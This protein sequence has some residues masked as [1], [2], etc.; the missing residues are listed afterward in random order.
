[1][2]F[3]PFVFA[4]SG[5]VD[6]N[7]AGATGTA[8]I[9]SGI[10]PGAG[11]V[12]QDEYVPELRGINAYKEYDKMRKSDGQVKGILA[13]IKL[14]LLAADWSLQ[15]PPDP[16]DT[17]RTNTEEI[18][19]AL[20]KR[21]W[22]YTLRHILL[23]LDFGSMPMEKVWTIE[24]G[25]AV[26]R[27]SPRLPRTVVEWNADEHGDFMGITQQVQ[28]SVGFKQ[29]HIEA[30]KLLLFINELEGS[31]FRGLS[32]LRAARKDW[33][34]KDKLQRINAITLEKRGAGID[35]GTILDGDEAIKG[36]A[37]DVLMQIRTHER[38]YVLETP[39]F[40]YRQD[41]LGASGTLSPLESIKYHDWSMLFGVMAQFLGMG[42]GQG[43]SFAMHADKTSFFLMSLLG[44]SGTVLEPFNDD[45]LPQWTTYNY[46]ENVR[47][48]TLDHSRLDRRD[49]ANVVE[50]LKALVPTGVIGVT[51]E[52]EAWIRGLLEMPE[53]AD[54]SAMS[55]R[56]VQAR[57][58]TQMAS[59]LERRTFDP[60]G[61][62]TPFIGEMAAAMGSY[63][64]ARKH[65]DALEDT[66]KALAMVRDSQA[67][68]LGMMSVGSKVHG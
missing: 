46:G 18:E 55:W 62:K 5:K 12:T 58:I 60:A 25:K 67:I 16:T 8:I 36:V 65:A 28:T 19:A 30:E 2:K 32:V 41:G 48:P 22:R 56:M 3:G 27:L 9:P 15:P 40:K 68:R 29:V 50:A 44:I 64:K 14:P 13:A 66:I 11:S 52:D 39:N 57:Q 24:D 38:S 42:D 6:T 49:V 63:A 20:L 7:E 37:E 34:Y 51:P 61:I 21:K 23:H 45:L 54:P 33:F 53:I 26:C 17:E 10:R 47:P 35:V 43:G 59:E 1:M 4:L 31:D